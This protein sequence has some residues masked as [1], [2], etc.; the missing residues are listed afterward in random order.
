M[1]RI[2]AALQPNN[3]NEVRNFFVHPRRNRPRRDAESVGKKLGEEMKQL[4]TR[5]KQGK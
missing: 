5:K 1:G 4:V 3:S 2:D